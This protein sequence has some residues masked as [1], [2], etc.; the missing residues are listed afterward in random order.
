MCIFVLS[1]NNK[2][3]NDFGPNIHHSIFFC[4]LERICLYNREIN[5]AALLKQN[6]KTNMIK[7]SDK[8]VIFK[9]K[10]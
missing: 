1:F 4:Y 2:E 8:I 3:N 5:L 6:S 7:N 9:N 10:S